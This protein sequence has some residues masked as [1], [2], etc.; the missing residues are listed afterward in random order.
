MNSSVQ[1]LKELC[2]YKTL[3]YCITT[4]EKLRNSTN[5]FVSLIKPHGAVT[6]STIG[7][8][9][10]I[11]LGQV[12]IDTERFS[13]HSTRWASTSEA[14]LSVSTDI[15]PANAGIPVKDCMMTSTI[16][17]EIS[18]FCK[19]CLLICIPAKKG[20]GAVDSWM[21]QILS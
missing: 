16:F 11:V 10:E 19:E 14:L 6:L 12:G 7:R 3:H 8:W 21:N 20:T 13:G 4:T 1:P 5:L 15:I 18:K 9:F 2:V 17:G